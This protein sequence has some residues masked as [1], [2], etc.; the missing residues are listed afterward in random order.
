MKNHTMYVV[1]LWSLLC[2]QT[3]LCY[4]TKSDV[5][6]KCSGECY[7][8]KVEVNTRQYYQKLELIKIDLLAKLGLDSPPRIKNDFVV[9][10]TLID[11]YWRE[12]K[13]TQ[14][15]YEKKQAEASTEQVMTYGKKGKMVIAVVF[16]CHPSHKSIFFFVILQVYMDS[17]TTEGFK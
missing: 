8:P 11:E 2:Y 3:W 12:A 13:R 1:L 4:P 10:Q 9:P 6:P 15:E 7:K 14:R 16:F 17:Q 5:K